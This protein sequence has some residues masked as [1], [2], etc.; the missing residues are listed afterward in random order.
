M[1]VIVPVTAPYLSYIGFVHGY[2]VTKYGDVLLPGFYQQLAESAVHF[3]LR[4]VIN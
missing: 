4:A 1:K 2:A 3:A